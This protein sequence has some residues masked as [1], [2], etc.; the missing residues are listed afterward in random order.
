MKA[1]VLPLKT[2]N[3]TA[4]NKLLLTNKH[5]FSCRHIVAGYQI[6]FSIFVGKYGI[7]EKGKVGG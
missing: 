3:T 6:I 7:A 2:R 5:M 4:L 1:N